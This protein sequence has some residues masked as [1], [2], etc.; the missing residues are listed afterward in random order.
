MVVIE[1]L[2]YINVTS[3]DLKKSVEFYTLFLDFEILEEAEEHAILMFDNLK[4]R[5]VHSSNE[6]AQGE[7]VGLPVLSF[8]MDVDDF[9]D[10]I[11]QIEEENIPIVSGPDEK[12]SGEAILIQDPGGNL[13]EFFYKE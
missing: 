8:I 13:I 4:F 11:Q 6:R 1:S 2:E 10:A 3:S 5:I 12:D 9:T 7:Q